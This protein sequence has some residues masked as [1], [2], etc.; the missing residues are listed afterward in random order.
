MKQGMLWFD[1]DPNAELLIK[2]NRAVAYTQQKYGRCPK[3]CFVH[4]SMIK[5]KTQGSNEIEVRASRSVLP[6]HF[7]LEFIK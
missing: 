1:D 6:N 5:E 2:I 3:L 7:W 4:P